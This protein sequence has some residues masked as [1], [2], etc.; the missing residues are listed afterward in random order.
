MGRAPGQ[1]SDLGVILAAGALALD[2]HG[3][4]VVQQAVQ[5]G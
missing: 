3:L 1:A 4:D 5:Q 2:Q